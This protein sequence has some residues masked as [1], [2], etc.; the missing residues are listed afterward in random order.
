[1]RMLKRFSL[2]VATAL[3]ICLMVPT[4][5]AQDAGVMAILPS[6]S[7]GL[8]QTGGMGLAYP[9]FPGR[10]GPFY[11]ASHC[12]NELDDS[13]CAPKYPEDEVEDSVSLLPQC[14]DLADL[15]DVGTS[16]AFGNNPLQASS[17]CCNE[18]DNSCC[19]PRYPEDEVEDSVSFQPEN[20][21]LPELSNVD[22]A[23]SFG[24]DWLQEFSH[25]CDDDDD[26]CCPENAFQSSRAVGLKS[27][28]QIAFWLASLQTSG[29]SIWDAMGSGEFSYCCNKKDKTCCPLMPLPA[30]A[31]SENSFDWLLDTY[32]VPIEDLPSWS[33]AFLSL[34]ANV[35]WLDPP[36]CCSASMGDSTCCAQLTKDRGAGGLEAW[37]IA[38]ENSE[39]LE[40]MPP[41]TIQLWFDGNQRT[42]AVCL[43]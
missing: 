13:C 15:R 33:V 12:C 9:T 34:G 26:S 42:R 20:F 35:A 14:F 24:N 37:E 32:D 8:D 28:T 31:I 2:V 39:R 40:T 27:A 6:L 7:V 17:H 38:G 41:G 18:Y 21:Q 11:A 16:T 36:T 19:A 10:N 30:S 1:M 3:G 5:D 4:G 29:L 22:V 25:C 23:S 43:N